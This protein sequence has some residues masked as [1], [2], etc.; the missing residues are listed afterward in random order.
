MVRFQRIGLLFRGSARCKRDE[1]ED[2]EEITKALH[3]KE[4]SNKR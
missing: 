3:G 1:K 4:G 2:E